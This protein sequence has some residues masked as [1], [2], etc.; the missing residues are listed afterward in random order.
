[1]MLT[2]ANEFTLIYGPWCQQAEA[3]LPDLFDWFDKKC[4]QSACGVALTKLITVFKV[5]EQE[6]S[7]LLIQKTDKK[8]E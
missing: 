8:A 1:M 6:W 5:H 7:I 2:E 4:D 3:K